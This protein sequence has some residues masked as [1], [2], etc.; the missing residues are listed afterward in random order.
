[1][2]VTAKRWGINI[3]WFFIQLWF[4]GDEVNTTSTPLLLADL[5]RFE[6]PGGFCTKRQRC[7]W[8]AKCF[9]SDDISNA[10]PYQTNTE[11]NCLQ[12]PQVRKWSW[13]ETPFHINRRLEGETISPCESDKWKRGRAKMQWRGAL[14]GT[15]VLSRL[16]SNVLCCAR[17]ALDRCTENAYVQLFT[18]SH[19]TPFLIFWADPNL[20]S[21]EDLDTK[22]SA[23]VCYSV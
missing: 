4:P 19:P 17:Y 9:S 15:L 8:N 7:V 14:P 18:T 13:K 10:E 22:C 5:T 16:H 6:T 11:P 12:P 20:L 1:M 2:W 3:D 23:T 21:R